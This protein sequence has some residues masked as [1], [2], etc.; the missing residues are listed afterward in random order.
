V[1]QKHTETSFEN[2]WSIGGLYILAHIIKS[3]F[4]AEAI[5]ELQEQQL[6]WLGLVD[7]SNIKA[8]VDLTLAPDER[9]GA[10]QLLLTAGQ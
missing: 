4:S 1:N 9:V 3:E 5:K 6:N 7:I 2:W 8:F 10:R